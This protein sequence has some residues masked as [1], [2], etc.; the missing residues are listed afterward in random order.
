M[1]NFRHSPKIFIDESG[2]TGRPD[3]RAI[4]INGEPR[5]FVM[6]FCCCKDSDRMEQKLKKLLN[7]VQNNDHYPKILNELKFYP[8]IALRKFGINYDEIQTRWEP[9]YDKIRQ[10]VLKI[11]VKESDGVFAAIVDKNKSSYSDIPLQFNEIFK[12]SLIQHILPNLDYPT[13]PYIIHDQNLIKGSV[14][15]FY[16]NMR[17]AHPYCVN[18]SN[19]NSTTMPGIWASDFV[20]GSFHLALRQNETKYRDRL[21]S[22]FIGS[23]S[24][25]FEIN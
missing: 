14:K 12:K 25:I 23:G 7:A 13:A 2:H 4:D 20:A 19:T 8:T 1:A 21:V 17:N 3:L 15:L 5:F 6:G 24:E 9:K 16:K 10:A 11:I 22:K 18:I